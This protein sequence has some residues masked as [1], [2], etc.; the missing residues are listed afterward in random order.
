M[1]RLIK[2][3]LIV[4]AVLLVI[5]LCVFFFILPARVEQSMNKV[6]QPPPYNASEKA[7]ALHKKLLVAD[8]HADPLLW[9]RDLLVKGTRGHIDVPRLIEGNVA[10]QVFSVVTKTPRNLNI[11]HN[12]DTTDNVFLL[13]LA[14]RAP[15]RTWNSLKERALYQSS[16]LQDMANNSNGKLTLIKTKSDL[17]KFLERKKQEPNIVSGMLAIEGAHA[18]DGDAANVDVLFNAGFRMMSPAHFFD[19]EM[20]GSAH[21]VVKGGLTDKGREMIQKM[22]AKRMIVD[23]A[24]ASQKTIE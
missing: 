18:L 22:E 14:Q 19:T 17:T 13:Y 16:R 9:G 20:S 24:H 21:G 6:L 1:K 12:D 10:L 5:G 7:N 23:I 15:L 8:L 3:L 11:E 2:R 4:I